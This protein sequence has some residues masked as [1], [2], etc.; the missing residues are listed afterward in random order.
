MTACLHVCLLQS[1]A[2]KSSSL[3]RGKS[4]FSSW[5]TVVMSVITEL[6]GLDWVIII[7]GQ[8]VSL[9]M[10]TSDLASGGT[11]PETTKI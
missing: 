7:S 10:S 3:K 4:I 1:V 8:L 2:W 9:S 11:G 6:E 5:Y